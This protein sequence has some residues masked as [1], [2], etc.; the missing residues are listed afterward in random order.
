MAGNVMPAA[1]PAIRPA[2]GSD[3]DRIVALDAEAAGMRRADFFHKRW[4]AMQAAPQDYLALVADG[5]DSVDGFAMAHILSGEF[6]DDERYAILDGFA[7]DAARRR[8]G[9][10]GA[11][12]EAIKDAARVLGCS[13]IRTQVQWSRQDLLAFLAGL[14][15]SPAPVLVLERGF[16]D[17]TP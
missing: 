14:D 5:G 6:G 2:D 12:I 11:L 9:T 7:V 13:D 10:G 17:S 16:E 3:L 8:A 1:A 15:F 4:H